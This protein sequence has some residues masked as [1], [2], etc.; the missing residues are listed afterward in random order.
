[1]KEMILLQTNSKVEDPLQIFSYSREEI[2]VSEP[3]I[4]CSDLRSI[5]VVHLICI[6]LIILAISCKE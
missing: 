1:V 5:Y 4:H 6:L 2:L 3:D